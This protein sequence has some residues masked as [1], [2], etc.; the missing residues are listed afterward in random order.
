MKREIKI[1]TAVCF[2]I[3]LPSAFALGQEKKVEKRVKIV[4]DGDKGQEVILDTLIIG[5]PLSDSIV[6]N[7]GQ[8]IILTHEEN[9]DAD[10]TMEPK[11]YLIMTSVNDDVKPDKQINKKVTIIS[12]DQDPEKT[13]YVIDRDGLMITVEGSDYNKVKE[14]TKEI[15][16][17][18]NKK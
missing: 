17:F 4:V 11:K 18:L 2:M 12:S 9:D 10:G 15:E 7:N 1:I 5:K 16:K 6:L 3:L 14:L 8:T 13:K